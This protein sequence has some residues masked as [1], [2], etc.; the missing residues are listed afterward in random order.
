MFRNVSPFLNKKKKNKYTEVQD[1]S[2]FESES[3]GRGFAGS[4][5]F[6]SLRFFLKISVYWFLSHKTDQE[7]KSKPAEN[8]NQLDFQQ[9][10]A[11]ITRYLVIFLRGV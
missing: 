3:H 2:L 8:K 9:I 5:G 11:D 7:K 6:G 10:S 1:Y 4:D